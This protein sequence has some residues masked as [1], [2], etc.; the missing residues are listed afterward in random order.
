MLPPEASMAGML[1]NVIS[2]G[3]DATETFEMGLDL[4]SE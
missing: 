3:W 4:V 1:T 2:T